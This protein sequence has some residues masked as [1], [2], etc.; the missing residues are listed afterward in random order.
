MLPLL[1]GAAVPPDFQYFRSSSSVYQK[2]LERGGLRTIKRENDFGWIKDLGL[3]QIAKF[4]RTDTPPDRELLRKHGFKHGLILWVP[5]HR[6]DVPEGWR[7]LWIPGSHFS[8][9]GYAKLEEEYFKKWN[10][11]ARRARKKSIS[12]GVEIRE[13]TQDIFI[14]AFS[15]TKV[16]H[17]FRADY[18]KY[19]RSMYESGP[20][21]IRSFLAYQ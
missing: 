5:A 4:E 2:Y 20:D 19:Y 1:S 12:S 3:F 6:D 8:I 18:I 7:E 10:E 13:V 16:R 11:R 21:S 15:N 17:M 9:T 14:E